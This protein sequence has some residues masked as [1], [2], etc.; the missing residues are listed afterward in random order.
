MIDAP[1]DHIALVVAD[2]EATIALYTQT[3][4]FSFVYRETVADLKQR[5]S[6]GG[7]AVLSGPRGSGKT[8][9][10]ARLAELCRPQS[11]ILWYSCQP[12]DSV[13]N[14]IENLTAFC[15]TLGFRGTFA[16]TKPLGQFKLAEDLVRWLRMLDR[17][18]LLILDGVRT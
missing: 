8:Y 4:G 5:V 2:L 16:A 15:G 17:P 6:V 12:Y 10:A 3:L 9:L 14:L 1:I 13:E 11:Y 18:A 7:V